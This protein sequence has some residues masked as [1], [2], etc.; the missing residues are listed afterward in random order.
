MST[1][2]ELTSEYQKKIEESEVLLFM[3]GTP[4]IPMCG[5]SAAALDG[6]RRVGFKN[7][8]T[9][10]ILSDPNI[11]PAIKSITQWPTFPQIFIRKQFIGGAD[12]LRDMEQKGE[13]QQLVNP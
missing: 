10:D 13:L 2:E 5:F 9:V 11:R 8:Q 6:L 1:V 4:E 3:K 7:I 12:I